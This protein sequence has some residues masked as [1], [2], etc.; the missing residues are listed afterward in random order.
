MILIGYSPQIITQIINHSR[1]LQA[2]ST[3]TLLTEWT[4]IR[5]KVKQ[6]ERKSLR[7]QI[8]ENRDLST[9][10]QQI[11]R[12]IKSSKEIDKGLHIVQS[13]VDICPTHLLM[14]VVF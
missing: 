9:L 7:P 3:A 2:H 1:A 14:F 10:P 13:G 11:N 6:Q 8:V 5:K 12:T 4:L